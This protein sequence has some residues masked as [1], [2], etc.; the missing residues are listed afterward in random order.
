MLLTKLIIFLNFNELDNY[1]LYIKME[2]MYWRLIA[3]LV[4][5]PYF[6]ISLVIHHRQKCK[7]QLHKTIESNFRVL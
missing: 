4:K 2:G 1:I 7:S 3:M 5:Q 6:S